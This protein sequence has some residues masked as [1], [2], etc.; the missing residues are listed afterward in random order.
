MYKHPLDSTTHKFFIIY[1][2]NSFYILLN[3]LEISKSSEASKHIKKH[4][5]NPKSCDNL[6]VPVRHYCTTEQLDISHLSK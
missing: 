3:I 2:L 5:K 6:Q 4:N 1:Y